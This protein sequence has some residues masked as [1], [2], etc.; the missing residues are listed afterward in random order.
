MDIP[1]PHKLENKLLHIVYVFRHRSDSTGQWPLSV[2]CGVVS[3]KLQ[4]REIKPQK[5]IATAL[6]PEEN[7]WSWGHW[8]EWHLWNKVLQK[9]ELPRSSSGNLHWGYS[10]LCANAELNMYRRVPWGASRS[11]RSY[12]T[13]WSSGTQ[14]GR[15]WLGTWGVQEIPKNMFQIMKVRAL[16]WWP[17]GRRKQMK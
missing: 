11:L 3:S 17:V 16:C 10:N 14:N 2:F 9:R 1:L 5:T 13:C 6:G 4:H 12:G 15:P 8:S 7:D